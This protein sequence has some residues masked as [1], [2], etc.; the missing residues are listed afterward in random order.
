MELVSEEE[1]EFFYKQLFLPPSQ[2]FDT[3]LS[4]ARIIW[5]PIYIYRSQP[6]EDDGAVGQAG[7]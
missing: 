2:L 5:L 4:A 7:R 1:E 6:I 3:G